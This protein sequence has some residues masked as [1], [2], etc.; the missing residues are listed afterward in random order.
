MTL[1]ECC[2][3]F[4]NRSAMFAKQTSPFACECFFRRVILSLSKSK[5][6]AE[7]EDQ[8]TGDVVWDLGEK[9]G[10]FDCEIRMALPFARTRFTRL[11]FD[12]G[13]R[14]SLKMTLLCSLSSPGL[15]V[16]IRMALPFAR[17]RFTRLGFDYGLRPSLKMTLLCL[18]SSP[19]LFV[20]IRMAL[21]FARTRFTRLGFDSASL[22]SR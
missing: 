21:P 6:T 1:G 10:R 5:R 15:F 8:T 14:T 2:S 22:R 19:G 16:Q 11:G 12:Y 20:Q 13:L 18:L 17:T 3:L 9:V 7:S 4:T